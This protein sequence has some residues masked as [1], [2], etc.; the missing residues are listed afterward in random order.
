M[1]ENFTDFGLMGGHGPYVWGAYGCALLIIGFNLISAVAH[2]R[3]VIELNRKRKSQG[4]D[5]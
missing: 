2:R 4:C 3:K 1:F 5:S